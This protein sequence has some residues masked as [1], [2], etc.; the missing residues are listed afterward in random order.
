MVDW[1]PGRGSEQQ[2]MRPAVIVQTD[3]ANAN[4]RYPNTIIVSVSTKGKNVP[5]HVRIEPSWE[6]GLQQRSYAKC[7]QIMTISKERLQKKLGQLDEES[8]QSVNKAVLLVLA[9]PD[10]PTSLSTPR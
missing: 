4:D 5:F 2:G 10:R 3:A 6:T 9:L 8:M 7:E 1:S